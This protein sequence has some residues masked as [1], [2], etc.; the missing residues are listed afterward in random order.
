VLALELYTAA[1]ALE[2]RQDMLNAART[3]AAR[4][5]WRALAR[6]IAGAP[7][8]DSKH[9]AQFETETNALMAALA[10]AGEFHAGAG[11]RGA[12]S[13]IRERIA[14]LSRDRTL[15]GDIGAICELVA[16]GDLLH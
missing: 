2:Y 13:A 16:R 3:L 9:Y 7:H 5:D 6:K 10:M 1:Q 11:V 4:G 14:F 8:A 12:F 15:D